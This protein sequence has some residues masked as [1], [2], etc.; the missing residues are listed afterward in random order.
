MNDTTLTVVQLNFPNAQ[1]VE[2]GDIVLV[3]ETSKTVYEV[4]AEVSGYI[5]YFAEVGKD[6]AV[7]ETVARIVSAVDQINTHPSQPGPTPRPGR[8]SP[9]PEIE[10]Q[11]ET[12]FSKAAERLLVS[13]GLEKSLFRSRDFV[14]KSDV[15]SL[16]QPV[17]VTTLKK[18]P[19]IP[20]LSPLVPAEADPEKVSVQKLS[21]SKR[22][23]I[24][25]LGGVQEGGLVSTLHTSFKTSG[26][27]VALNP[28]LRILKNS[29][30]PLIIYE[31]SRLLVKY[32]LLNAYYHDGQVFM[33]RHV[34]PG[35]AIDSGKGLKVLK[36]QGAAEQSLQ[37]TESAIVALSELYLEDKLA[38]TDISEVTFTITDLTAESVTLF[39]PLINYRNS[40]ILGISAPDQVLETCMVSLAFD[41]RVTEGKLVSRFLGELVRRLESYLPGPAYKASKITCSNCLAPLNQEQNSIGFVKCIQPSGAEGYICQRCFNGF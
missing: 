28:S 11:G 10:L 27:Q 3:F 32:P 14:S 25:Y 23:E 4:V 22:K 38:V 31:V 17:P 40:A 12:L 41:H 24:E 7:N 26:L 9:L 15:E 19:G 2:A 37:E 29:M 18:A 30:L 8:N 16:S 20:A 5:E 36:V 1:Q 6:Y 39:N 34:N 35:F 33:Y 13:A 21:A